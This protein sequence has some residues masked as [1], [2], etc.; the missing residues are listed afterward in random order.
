[1]AEPGRHS[2]WLDSDRERGVIVVLILMVL[3]LFAVGIGSVV[4]MMNAA[5]LS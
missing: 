4:E 2:R 1:M 5:S 3:V